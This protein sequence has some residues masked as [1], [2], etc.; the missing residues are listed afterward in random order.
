VLGLVL[1]TPVILAFITTNS[2]RGEA[3]RH[4]LIIADGVIGLRA[5]V[6]IIRRKHSRAWLLYA[7]LYPILIIVAAVLAWVFAPDATGSPH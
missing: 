7:G 5:I 2:Y 4:S 3:A 1:L 6:G